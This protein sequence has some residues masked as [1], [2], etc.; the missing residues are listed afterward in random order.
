[1]TTCGR[2][3]N[4]ALCI[5]VDFGQVVQNKKA[6]TTSD[7]ASNDTMLQNKNLYHTCFTRNGEGT[8]VLIN[9]DNG[10]RCI[11]GMTEDPFWDR[12]LYNEEH[13]RT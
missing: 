9:W 7:I 3:N 5:I 10:E 4:D 8:R 2:A 1:M 13:I 12:K 6:T 11:T